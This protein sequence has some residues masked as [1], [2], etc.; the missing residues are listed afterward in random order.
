TFQAITGEPGKGSNLG[1]LQGRPMRT[2]IGK[3]KSGYFF[4]FG[5][6]E[7]AMTTDF[8][9]IDTLIRSQLDAIYFCRHPSHCIGV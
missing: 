7:R 6:F 1:V 4:E 2:F 8:L 9:Q 5:S 3:E